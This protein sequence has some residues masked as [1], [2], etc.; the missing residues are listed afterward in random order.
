MI[1]RRA[2]LLCALLV[3][4]AAPAVLSAQQAEMSLSNPKVFVS[5][6]R[7]PV[8][9]T[10]KYHMAL[11]GG[12]CLVCHHRFVRGKNALGIKDL[13]EGDPSL[14]CSCCHAKPAQLQRVFHLQCIS[15]HEA[16][17]RNGAVNPP[18]ACGECHAAGR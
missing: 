2:V 4:A 17:S 12:N 1:L 13:K 14:R 8:R 3:S 10:H 18:R 7:G 5:M 15:C 9:F 11:D 16:S 6:N